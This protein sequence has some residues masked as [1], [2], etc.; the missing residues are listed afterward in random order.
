[1]F[2]QQ[3]H[4]AVNE[5]EFGRCVLVT[6]V[7]GEHYRGLYSTHGCT[8]TAKNGRF[9]WYSGVARTH[10]T[11]RIARGEVQLESAKRTRITCSGEMGA[12]EYSGAGLTTVGGVVFDLTGCKGLGQKCSSP[13]GPAGEIATGP[14]EGTLGIARRARSGARSAVALDLAPTGGAGSFAVFS[15]GATSVTIRGSLVGASSSDRMGSSSTLSFSAT[16][17][18]QRLQGLVGDPA[19]PLEASFDG[20]PFERIGLRLVTTLV[21]EEAME[22][23]LSHS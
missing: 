14:L 13:G 1:V 17:G 23:R 20:G 3:P 6:R 19:Q 9:E 21:D 5:A 15:C 12:G 7:G 16:K 11:T 8:K 2:V 10:F 4:A 18:I 22:A